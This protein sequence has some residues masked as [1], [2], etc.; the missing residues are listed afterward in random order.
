MTNSLAYF[1]SP[2][3]VKKKFI[4]LTPVQT[5]QLKTAATFST[6][7]PGANQIKTFLA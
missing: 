3:A 1:A 6:T 2:S 5:Q 4:Q 7:Q